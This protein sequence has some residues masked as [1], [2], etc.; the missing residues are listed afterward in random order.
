[1]IQTK[2][3]PEDRV[4]EFKAKIFKIIGDSNRLKILEILRNGENCQ[5]EIIPLIEQS[6]PTVSRHLKLLED[7][8]LISSS[9][10]GTRV[11]YSVVDPHIFNLID[12]ID[13]EMIDLISQELAKKIGL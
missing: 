7:A 11:F 8:G 2:H 1:M 5:C 13:E 6:Q 12:A 10:D 9:K 4:L 3:L